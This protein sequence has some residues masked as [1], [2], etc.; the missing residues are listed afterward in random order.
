MAAG[1]LQWKNGTSGVHIF[2]GYATVL[3]FMGQAYCAQR[4]PEKGMD[5]LEAAL[6][7]YQDAG[8]SQTSGAAGS[9]ALGARR[10]RRPTAAE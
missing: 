7:S 6:K 1:P 10:R 9:A 8:A 2:T 5:F 4:L 3:A